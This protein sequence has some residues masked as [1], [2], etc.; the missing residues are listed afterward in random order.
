MVADPDPH[1]GGQCMVEDGGG[2]QTEEDGKGSLEAGTE[3]Q[4]EKLGFVAEFRDGDREGGEQKGVHRSSLGGPI[5]RAGTP[6]PRGP[7]PFGS[8]STKTILRYPPSR[9]ADAGLSPATYCGRA[10][11]RLCFPNRIRSS[12]PHRSRS[13]WFPGTPTRRR[14]RVYFPSL[15]SKRSV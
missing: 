8:Y 15:R 13:I 14:E 12:S 3:E 6:H 7:S 10:M 2:E 5:S 11:V 4:R 1:H 9:M